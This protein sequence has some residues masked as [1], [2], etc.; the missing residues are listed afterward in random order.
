[1]ARFGDGLSVD[2]DLVRAT[3]EATRDALEQLD[4]HEPDLVCVF[5]CGADP[6]EMTAVRE[7][8]AA[9]VGPM[10]T[11][12]GCTA[13]GVIGGGQAVERTPSVSAWAASLPGAEIKGFHLDVVRTEDS[14]A[15]LGLP[16]M[17]DGDEIVVLLA[18]PYTFPV[19]SF[20]ERSN[21]VL[22]GVP[23]VGGLATGP[24]GQGSTRLILDDDVHE[25]GAV[26]LVLGGAV[27]ASTLVSQGCRPVGPAM[28]VT[29][30]EENVLLELA[31][32]PA[33]AK[34]QE[35]VSA[36]A[37]EDAEL[38]ARGL[39]VGVAMDEYAD[40][41]ERGD[42]LI[43][44][45]IGADQ[46]RDA[47]VIG[48]VVEVGQTVRFQVRDADAAEEDL[49][50][51]LARFRSRADIGPVE[52]ALLFSCNGRGTAL[53]PSADHDVRA[54]RAGLST[55]GVAGFFAA[56]EIGPVGGRNHLHGFTASLL[57][58]GTRSPSPRRSRQGGA[59]GQ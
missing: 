55:G 36:L 27:A 57:A 59:H 30:A 31:G 58:F 28:T 47:L 49:S 5:V 8:A 40:Q 33:V 24:L 23:L 2:V 14:L 53:F 15:V 51:T 19:D 37:P 7:R 34:L 42:F 50:E 54:I 52:G 11:L 10:T 44:G 43:R 17:E 41:H 4:G 56:G 18:D 46:E 26:G 35:V 1:M 21:D 45:V 13:G 3:E 9:Q 29:A 12:L 16:E 25:R 38:V 22:P 48:D 39:H 20:V 32:T 6:A